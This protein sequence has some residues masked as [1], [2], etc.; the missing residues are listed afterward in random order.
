MATAF[1]ASRVLLTAYELDLFTVLGERSCLSGEIA[2][3]LGTDERATDRLMNALCGLDFL[4]KKDGRFSNTP[5][6]SQFLVRDKPEFIAGLMH[7]VHLWETWST[8]TA[9]VRQGRSVANRPQNVKEHS[10][11][12]LRAF[13]AAMHWRARQHAP[14][15]VGLIDLSN[16]SRVL[17]VGGGSGAYAMAFAKAKPDLS[18]AVFDL[19]NVIPMTEEYI[20]R[21]GLAGRVATIAGDYQ[22][23]IFG[24]GFDLVFLS[25]IIHSN[26]PS[27]NRALIAK[28]AEALAPRGQMVV[29]DFIV[30]EDRTGPPFAVLFALNMLVGTEAGDTYTES[31]VRQW[32]EGAGL[33]SVERKDTPF[34]TSLIVGRRP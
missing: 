16:V 4:S 22:C 5:I 29:Q 12:W 13:I 33:Q 26:S 7:M 6:A 17:D 9:A 20:H 3:M 23:D 25:A 8:L 11:D 14:G 32:M 15:V 28:A 1:Q 30:N 27:Q 19:P 2:R 34:G 31:E 24:N 10:E 18:A 21:E